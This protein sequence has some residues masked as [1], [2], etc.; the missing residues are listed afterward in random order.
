MHKI[1]NILY[2]KYL[3]ALAHA[4]D[5]SQC[6]AIIV[7]HASDFYNM[8]CIHSR[9]NFEWHVL[10]KLRSMRLCGFAISHRHACT[11]VL[12][13]RHHEQAPLLNAY[14][15]WTLLCVASHVHHKFWKMKT[16]IKQSFFQ[17]FTRNIYALCIVNTADAFQSFPV[18]FRLS[19]VSLSLFPHPAIPPFSY[20]CM[21]I[22]AFV[23]LYG[24]FFTYVEIFICNGSDM[25]HFTDTFMQIEQNA[26]HIKF[27]CVF[28]VFVLF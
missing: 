21:P 3:N 13:K 18:V 10:I 8:H 25:V 2:W 20:Q 7:C 4:Y 28:S 9:R 26:V 16:K 19:P 6:I 22:I 27:G 15:P 23:I 12:H 5:V 14:N 24:I 17:K 11:T 1:G